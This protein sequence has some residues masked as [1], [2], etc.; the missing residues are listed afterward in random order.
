MQS[1]GSVES[2]ANLERIIEQEVDESLR[3]LPVELKHFCELRGLILHGAFPDYVVGGTVYLNIDSKRGCAAIN[4]ERVPLFPLSPAL[5][6]VAKHV[7]HATQK[8]FDANLFLQNI[9]RAYEVCLLRRASP[10]PETQARRVPI[11]EILAE[12]AMERQPEAF[13]RNPTKDRFRAYSQHDFRADLYC[14]LSAPEV[15]PVHN[16]RLVLEPTSL[17]DD[18]LFMFLPN[19]GR[20][21]FVGY[22]VFSPTD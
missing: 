8:A 17:A 13:R 1:S 19:I 4:G 14:L 16:L 18:G 22:L 6:E 7:L 3:T 9:W 2:L 11:F 21:G 20:C 10:A 5:D 15:P 12:M